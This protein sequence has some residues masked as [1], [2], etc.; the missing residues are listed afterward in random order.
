MM[1][2]KYTFLSLLIGLLLY[3][4]YQNDLDTSEKT[5]ESDLVYFDE[6][7]SMEDFPNDPFRIIG[8][9]PVENNWSIIVEYSGGC[10]DHYFY[11]WWDGQISED[12]ASFYIFHNANNDACKAI[13]RDTIN[14]DINQVLYGSSPT[15]LTITAMN[16]SNGNKIVIDP[17][18]A[19]LKQSDECN[20]TATLTG[21]SCGFG[22]WDNQ[23][24]ILNEKIDGYNNIWL[25]PVSNDPSVG[26]QKPELGIYDISFTILFGHEYGSDDNDVACL[27]VPQGTI[28][29]ISVTC[30]KK[31]D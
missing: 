27:S 15:K 8:I 9:N 2:A 18:L 14:L 7:Q 12:S 26:L 6:R 10:S 16:S 13:V 25:Q 20:Y 4:C 5:S 28:L 22:L 23:W 3:G 21:T 24:F 11:T 17:K 19:A 29:P 1:S 30:L 31:R